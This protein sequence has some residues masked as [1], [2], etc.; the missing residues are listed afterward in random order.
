MCAAGA[1]VQVE[2]VMAILKEELMTTMQF[3][4]TTTPEAVA[5]SGARCLAGV[6]QAMQASSFPL[7]REHASSLSFPAEASKP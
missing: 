3:M 2:R 6:E 5:R 7:G 4:G 1:G